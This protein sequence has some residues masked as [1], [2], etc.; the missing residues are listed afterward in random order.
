MGGRS[1]HA[2][3]LPALIKMDVGPILKNVHFCSDFIVF[4]SQ[5]GVL[6]KVVWTASFK[7]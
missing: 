4:R 3:A 1:E 5:S 6:G 2:S 7:L